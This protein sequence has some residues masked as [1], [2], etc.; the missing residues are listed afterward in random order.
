MAQEATSEYNYENAKKEEKKLA[1]IS[2]EIKNTYSAG[3]FII[4]ITLLFIHHPY[5]EK[6]R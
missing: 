5:K 3:T 4:T 1:V 2:L 6:I